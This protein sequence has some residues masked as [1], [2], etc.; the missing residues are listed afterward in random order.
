MGLKDV[1][2]PTT[3]TRHACLQ[4]GQSSFPEVKD[5]AALFAMMTLSLCLLPV[6]TCPAALVAPALA[7]PSH[8]LLPSFLNPS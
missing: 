8:P 1:P 3:T 6:R 5:L 4:L 2:S 7:Q